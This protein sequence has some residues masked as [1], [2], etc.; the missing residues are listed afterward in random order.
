MYCFAA[1]TAAVVVAMVLTLYLSC[2][3]ILTTVT[4]SAVVAVSVPA[5]NDLDAAVATTSNA[6]DG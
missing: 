3:L 5:T 6:A 4:G 1:F 2:S